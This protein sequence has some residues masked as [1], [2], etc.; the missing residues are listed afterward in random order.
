MSGGGEGVFVKEDI[1]PDT[2][3]VLFNGV[4]YP[5]CSNLIKGIGT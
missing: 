5:L 3:V 1:L 2:V 4:K